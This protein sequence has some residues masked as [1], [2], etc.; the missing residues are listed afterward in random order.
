MPV[1]GPPARDGS[2]RAGPKFK[3]GRA[4]RVSVQLGRAGLP[5]RVI[6]RVALTVGQPLSR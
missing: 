5:L 6:N 1:F 3:A 2:H 4:P